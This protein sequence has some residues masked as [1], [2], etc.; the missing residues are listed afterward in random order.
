MKHKS[1]NQLLCAATVNSRFR[2][3]LLHDPAKALAT[4]YYGQTFAL[5]SEEQDLVLSIR[6]RGLEDFAAQVYEWLTT[7]N[8]GHCGQSRPSRSEADR[9]TQLASEMYR[10]PALAH[11]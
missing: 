3:V 11:A 7:S 2:E 6:A 5:T 1:L 9:H 8:N 10:V 4:G